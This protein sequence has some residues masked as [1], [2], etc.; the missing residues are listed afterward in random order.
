MMVYQVTV[1]SSAGYFPFFL[2]T[3]RHPRFPSD[4]SHPPH[5]P[6]GSSPDMYAFE[7]QETS[8]LADNLACSHLETSYARQ[9]IYLGQQVNNNPPAPDDDVLHR[10]PTPT[11][12]YPPSSPANGRGRSLSFKSFPLNL[13]D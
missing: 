10:R 4:S 1:H 12:G 13:Y 11:M 7:L 2:L 3:G 5:R 8:R 6:D 9:K